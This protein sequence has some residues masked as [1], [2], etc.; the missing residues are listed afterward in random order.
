MLDEK[1]WSKLDSHTTESGVM[2]G[3]WVAENYLAYSRLLPVWY[4]NLDILCEGKRD[5]IGVKCLIQAAYTSLCHL[6]T[7]MT[8]KP[9]VIDDYIKVFLSCVHALSPNTTK[10]PWWYKTGNIV[11]FLNF[12]DQI[13]EYGHLRLYWEGNRERY[14]QSVKPL[15]QNIRKSETYLELKMIELH[16]NMGLRELQT[17]AKI[18]GQW[19]EEPE[20]WLH[21]A[22]HLY[23]SLDDINKSLEKYKT[24][25]AVVMLRADDHHDTYVCVKNG[26]H[27]FLGYKIIWSRSGFSDM[28]VWYA[29]IEISNELTY[30]FAK[31]EWQTDNEGIMQVIIIST[32]NK[33]HDS[34]QVYSAFSNT[35]LIRDKDGTYN[36]PTLCVNLF[37]EY[38]Q[39]TL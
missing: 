1:N 14:I 19:C 35:W 25:S 36:V 24:L 4:V 30:K 20:D 15:L 9:S 33:S 2:T 16:T 37:K 6:M 11:S 12:H 32:I 31:K 26:K 10:I 13:V 23:Q 7:N 3:G 38:T 27:F 34:Q 5:A 21:K 17:S 28:G 22:L 29:P 8:I 39:R 18:E